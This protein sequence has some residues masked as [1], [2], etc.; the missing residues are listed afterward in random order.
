MKNLEGIFLGTTCLGAFWE[1]FVTALRARTAQVRAGGEGLPILGPAHSMA[2]PSICPP[3][4]PRPWLLAKPGAPDLRRYLHS[5]LRTTP[6]RS[7]AGRGR[8]LWRA[9]LTGRGT[10]APEGGGRAAGQRPDCGSVA[11][12][13]SPPLCCSLPAPQRCEVVTERARAPWPPSPESRC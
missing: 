5:A 2:P 1:H 11:G 4:R 8:D 12:L 13:A 10:A 7:C 9:P 3:I 6:R